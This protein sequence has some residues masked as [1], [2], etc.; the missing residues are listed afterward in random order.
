MNPSIKTILIDDEAHNINVLQS[1][2][3]KYFPQVEIIAACN[4]A[5]D[6]YLKIIELQPQ[7]VFLD[8]RMPNKS[9]F[10]LLKQFSKF[11]FEIIFVSAFNEYAITAFEFNALGYILKPI[12]YAKL[13][14]AVDKAIAKIALKQSNETVLHFVKTLEEKNDLVNKISFHHNGKVVFVNIVDIVFIEVSDDTTCITDI[15]GSKYCSS[16]DIK[17]Y[18]DLLIEFKQFIRISRYTIININCIKSYSKGEVCVIDLN[19]GK[20]FEVSRRKKTE[21]LEKIKVRM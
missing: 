5:D 13:I 8:I 11:N 2:L 10:D 20:S 12:D 9:G 6:G 7:L 1:L 4:N 14:L 21:V 15:M 18:E 3:N 16:K 19:N 17:L